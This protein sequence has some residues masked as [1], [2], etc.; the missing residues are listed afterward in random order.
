MLFRSYR[1]KTAP[2]GY[3]LDETVYKVKQTDDVKYNVREAL[4]KKLSP[5]IKTFATDVSTGSNIL[6]CS[7]EAKVID[8]IEYKNLEKGEEYRIKGHIV[9]KKTGKPLE[10]NGR[11]IEAEKSF[12]PASINGTE[13][14]EYTLDSRLL[15]DRILVVFEEVFKDNVSV[16]SHTDVNDENQTLL[17]P[18]IGTS[19]TD[20]KTGEHMTEYSKEAK[21]IDRVSYKNLVPG[22]EYTVSGILMDAESGEAILTEKGEKI[23]NTLAFTPESPDGNVDVEFTVDSKF[24]TGKTVVAFENCFFKGVRISYHEEIGRAHV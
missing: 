15:K 21:I 16:V 4:D 19:A 20:G 5:G 23:T 1:E 13:E 3:Q 6:S 24:L 8:R 12:R 17:V 10:I 14:L 18:E 7:P 9:D 2:E 22:I 11:R